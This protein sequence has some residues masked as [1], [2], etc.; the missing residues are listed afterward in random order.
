MIFENWKIEVLYSN[1]L[2][3]RNDEHIPQIGQ[4][5]SDSDFTIEL[6][7]IP[8]IYFQDWEIISVSN[9]FVTFFEIKRND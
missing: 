6:N 5:Q 3:K 1:D 2:S 7:Y 9:Y 4:F 8:R